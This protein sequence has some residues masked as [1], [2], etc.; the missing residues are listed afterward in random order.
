MKVFIHAQHG[1]TVGDNILISYLAKWLKQNF[2]CEVEYLPDLVNVATVKDCDILIFGPCGL[3]YDAGPK[4]S[5]DK[6][7][8]YTLDK[9]NVLHEAKRHGKRIFGFNLGVQLLERIEYQTL[10]RDGL[11]CCEVITTR[12]QHTTDKF[13]S[14]GVKVP[15]ITCGDLGFCMNMFPNS[16]S[17][18]VLGVNLMAY[19][20]AWHKAL[21]MLKESMEIRMMPFSLPDTYEVVKYGFI[22]PQWESC[23]SDKIL[24]WYEGLSAMVTSHV[25]SAIFSIMSD[26]PFLQEN[27]ENDKKAWLMSELGYKHLWRES[28][29]SYIL[30]ARVKLVLAHANEIKKQLA[31]YREQMKP[32]AEKNLQI[33]KEWMTS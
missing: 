8:D 18:M 17:K 31:R 15:I 30:V 22:V 3:V 2:N 21:Q 20:V 28:D 19:N 9:C 1:A 16:N 26:V 14:I 10:W 7:E 25:H 13:K 6:W 23:S 11:N 5:K 24:G 27:T 12:E 33:L 4:T 29:C 32:L